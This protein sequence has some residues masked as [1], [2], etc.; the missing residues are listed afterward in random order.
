MSLHETLDRRLRLLSESRKFYYTY[1][2][3][4]DNLQEKEAHVTVA[5]EKLAVAKRTLKIAQIDV[6]SLRYFLIPGTIQ[7]I[8]NHA[9][10]LE[11]KERESLQ[12]VEQCETVVM[13]LLSDPMYIDSKN[14]VES[15]Q[16]H[17][18]FR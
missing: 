7:E 8:N 13:R 10:K 15:Y 11:E 4:L 5:L 17:V 1:R 3:A 14:T 9:K 2:H 6:E 18:L 12:K 16:S